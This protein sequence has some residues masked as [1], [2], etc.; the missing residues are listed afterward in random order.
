[1]ARVS[2][3]PDSWR[4]GWRGCPRFVHGAGSPI[5]K[6]RGGQE[7]DNPTTT[8]PTRRPAVRRPGA[9]RRGRTWRA[10]AARATPTACRPAPE[11]PR[12]HPQQTRPAHSLPLR[13][14][15]TGFLANRTLHLFQKRTLDLFSTRRQWRFKGQ[16]CPWPMAVPFWLSLCG[17]SQTETT[18]AAP[19]ARPR[20]KLARPWLPLWP[21]PLADGCLSRYGCPN[22]LV[23]TGCYGCANGLEYGRPRTMGVPRGLSMGVPELWVSQ[24]GY[25]CPKGVM[26][27]PRGF[28]DGGLWGWGALGMGVPGS[29][30]VPLGVGVGVG[31]PERWVPGC[32]G[33][34]RFLE[35]DLC[36]QLGCIVK[37]VEQDQY[38]VVLSTCLVGLRRSLASLRVRVWGCWWFRCG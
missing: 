29:M 17:W 28:G 2:A 13:Q 26:G 23:P 7:V 6:R 34:A 3:S 32:G 24:G 1:M 19:L 14:S 37:N 31:V 30:G 4:R 11:R 12:A 36:L 10:C 15:N 27:V 38:L 16:G 22:G 20:P 9:R 25:G 8:S 5:L 33:V 18:M 21:V 35:R